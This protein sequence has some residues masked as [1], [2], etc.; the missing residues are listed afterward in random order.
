MKVAEHHGL[1]YD[2]MESAMAEDPGSHNEPTLYVT[3]MR[4]PVSG[5]FEDTILSATRFLHGCCY[6]C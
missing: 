1:K 2:V 4:E 3:H 5:A 6:R